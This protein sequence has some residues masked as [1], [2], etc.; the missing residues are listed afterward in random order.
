MRFMRLSLLVVKTCP[1][2]TVRGQGKN[3]DS[4]FRH[5]SGTFHGGCRRNWLRMAG[6]GMLTA[7]GDLGGRTK[8]RV[9]RRNEVFRPNSHLR[10]YT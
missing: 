5:T 4:S 2:K 7:N 3:S 9:S 6:R 10:S 8:V 1:E